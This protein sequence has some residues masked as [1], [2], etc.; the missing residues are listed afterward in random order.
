MRGDKKRSIH[1]SPALLIEC[2]SGRTCS[3]R[4]EYDVSEPPPRSKI[5]VCVCAASATSSGRDSA[6][7]SLH[8]LKRKAHVI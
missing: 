3:R 8:P 7:T 2:S 1:S 5:Q 4:W 6:I